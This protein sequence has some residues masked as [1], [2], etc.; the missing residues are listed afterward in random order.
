V[1]ES[2]DPPVPAHLLPPTHPTVSAAGRLRPTAPLPDLERDWEVVSWLACSTQLSSDVTGYLCD[3]LLD[4]AL[5]GRGYPQMA[6][7]D[8][9]PGSDHLQVLKQI[10]D[11]IPQRIAEIP[12]V[13]SKLELGRAGRLLARAYRAAGDPHGVR[14]AIDRELAMGTPSPP[15]P[16]APA[17]PHTAPPPQSSPSESSPGESASSDASLPDGGGW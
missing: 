2:D 5:A 12:G 13:A 4:G 6:P 9:G 15:G 11:R 14:D 10:I 1:S 7:P 16:P 17:P 8:A 3:A